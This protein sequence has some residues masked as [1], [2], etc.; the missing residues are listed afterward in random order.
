MQQDAVADASPSTVRAHINVLVIITVPDLLDGNGI[1]GNIEGLV[2][3]AKPKIDAGDG[4][5]LEGDL[6]AVSFEELAAEHDLQW[7]RLAAVEERSD[8]KP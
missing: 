7:P 2:D 8:G 6:L 4:V 1:A 3:T 5:S